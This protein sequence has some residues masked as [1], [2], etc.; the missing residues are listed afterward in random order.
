M[1]IYIL[2]ITKGAARINMPTH[3]VAD[4]PVLSLTTP[5]KMAP[6]IPPTSKRIEISALKRALIFSTTKKKSLT[7]PWVGIPRVTVRRVDEKWQ[8]VQKR[9]ADQLR[10]EQRKRELDYAWNFAGADESYRPFVP[11]SAG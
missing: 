10:K 9:V 11:S 7:N 1:N 6:A 2:I 5:A 4:M 8:P 3:V